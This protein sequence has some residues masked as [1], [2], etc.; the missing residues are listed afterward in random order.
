MWLAKHATDAKAN[1][2]Y[3]AWLNAGG[4]TEL[5]KDCIAA[6]LAGH[7]TNAESQFCYRAWLDAGG[8]IAMIQ[9]SLVKWLAK[10]E[11]LEEATYVYRGWIDA[12]GD[13]EIIRESLIAWL[14]E[15]GESAESDFIYKA[16]LEKGGS[17]AVIRQYAIQWLSRNYEREEAVFLTKYL[18]KQ[19]DIPVETVRDILNWCRKFSTNEDALWRMMQLKKHL[20]REEVAKEVCVAYETILNQRLSTN[21]KLTLI[22]SGLISTL[23]AYLID[24]PAFQEGELRNR[25]DELL[26]RWLRHPASFGNDPKPHWNIQRHSYMWHVIE[27]IESGAL[28]VA[29]DRGAL[30]RFMLWVNNWEPEQKSHIRHLINYLKRK[31]PAQGLWDIVKF[32]DDGSGTSPDEASSDNFVE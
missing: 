32:E 21:I 1:F 14:E 17:F 20:L 26:L 22:D 28:S 23:F 5:V 16:W 12:G 30:E 2:V 25:V 19:A 13:K 10:Y 29:E 9:E 15:H 27:L 4:D 6:W 18:A 3:R 7:V 31:Y 11:A 24:A 8:E